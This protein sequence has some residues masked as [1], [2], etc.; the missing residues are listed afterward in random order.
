MYGGEE[1]KN[2]NEYIC[3]TCLSCLSN[4]YSSFV[5]NNNRTSTS[6]AMNGDEMKLMS[7]HVMSFNFSASCSRMY[8]TQ[9]ERKINTKEI[10]QHSV[11]STD[12]R[13][14]TVS[15]LINRCEKKSR[16]Y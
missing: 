6:N 10:E 7:C 12:R 4:Y 11:I 9:F 1:K 14:S 15:H 5:L 3:R 2:I 13:T 16:F 8:F